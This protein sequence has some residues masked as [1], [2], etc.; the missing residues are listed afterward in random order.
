ISYGEQSLADIRGQLI[1]RANGWYGISLPG[2]PVKKGQMLR[3]E[4]TPDKGSLPPGARL[5][6]VDYDIYRGGTLLIDG[7][8]MPGDG[9]F[10]ILQSNSA[11]EA[12]YKLVHSGDM[13]I[14]ENQDV[15]GK[16]PVVH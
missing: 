15:T 14:F 4:V 12:K 2:I 13:N 9:A 6:A 1:R 7:K 5:Y 11:L 16:L 10:S 3:F 8:S